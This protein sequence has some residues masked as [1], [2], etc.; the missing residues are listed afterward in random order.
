[1]GWM[2][3]TLHYLQESPV[4]RKYHH[5]LMTF[6][7]VYAFSEKFVLPISHDEV[8]H[9]KLS[10]LGRMPGDDWQK[11]A[12][13]RA[14]LAFMWAHPGKKLLFMGCEFGQVTEWNHDAELPWNLLQ[15]EA[16]RGVQG[17]VRHLN[18]AL[19]AHPALY[20]RDFDA[21][22]F[23]WVIGNDAEQSV[24]AFLRFDESGTAPLLVVCNFTPIP[25]HEYRIG[26]PGP[27]WR[28][29]FNSDATGFGGSG[30]GNGGILL[31]QAIP[32]H[33]QV[34][35]LVLTLPPLGVIYLAC[36]S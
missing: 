4:N 16:H 3:D 24:Y 31:A 19:Q 13:L 17:T 35:S 9:G 28:E 15:H 23:C 29:V 21:A 20:E 11:F 27:A 1:M 7:L 2:H 6:G 32:A 22:G 12:N 33:G 18:A 30:V 14:Y 5:D 36:D 10:L 8:V 25:R 26:V 34:Q